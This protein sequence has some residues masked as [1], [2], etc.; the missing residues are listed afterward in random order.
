VPEVKAMRKLGLIA[1]ATLK[2]G[3]NK[4]D[5]EGEPRD[6]GCDAREVKENPSFQKLLGRIKVGVVITRSGQRFLVRGRMRFKAQLECAICWQEYEQ[7]FDEEITAE[8]TTLEC[9]RSGSYARELE[10]VELDRVPIDAD[11]ID[12]S[13]L[14][15]DTIHLAIPIAPKCQNDCRGICP[16]CGANLN[17]EECRCNRKTTE[18]K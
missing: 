5:L 1:L 7:D 18:K 4:F 16:E 9:S 17:F 13:G 14:I 8:F 10:P 15:R 12:L 2:P 6:F 3:D 11:F